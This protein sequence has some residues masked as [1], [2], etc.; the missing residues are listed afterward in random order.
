MRGRWREWLAKR[1]ALPPGWRAPM[2]YLAVPL[3]VALIT[4][5]IAGLQTAFGLPNSSILYLLAVLALASTVGGR[6]AVLAACLAFLADN[7]F[8]VEPRYTFAIHDPEQWIT[9]V[10][11]LIVAVVAGQLTAALR[12]RAVEAQ[13]R[14]AMSVALFNSLNLALEARAAEAQRREHITATLYELS[15]ALVAGQAP[16][17][18]LLAITE[19]IVMLLPVRVCAVLLPDEQGL[20]RVRVTHL[21]RGAELAVIDRNEAAI[22]AWLA[23]QP[24]AAGGTAR[25]GRQMLVPLRAG[26]RLIGLL[27]VEGDTAANN[28]AGLD[29]DERRLLETFAAQA[30]LALEQARLARE[31][32]RAEILTR[33]DALKDTLLTSVSHDLRTPLAAIRAAAGSLLQEDIAWDA[34]ARHEF[35]AA[36]DDEAARLNRLVG[37]LLDMSRIDAGVLVAR[38]ELYPL[39]ALL[40]A[41]VARHQ[42][43]PELAISLEVAADLPPV[44]LD[45]VQIDQVLDNLLDNARKYAPP[46]TPVT[47]SALRASRGEQI[48]I[49][50]AD[51]GPGI[52][53]D[54]RERIF[55]KFGRLDRDAANQG[56]GLGLAIARGLVDA[57]GGRLWVEENPS[58]GARFVFSLPVTGLPV[59]PVDTGARL[60]GTVREAR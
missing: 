58:G 54:E 2:G 8:F 20:L 31:A 43:A 9:L 21:A 18:L 29:D 22:H 27:R 60:A 6:P 53:P 56:S 51:R 28:G 39:D 1:T 34:E 38:K 55:A 19:R 52:P 3:S 32:L 13:R 40:R 46:G 35:A 15:R 11:F 48:L 10:V 42:Y 5:L 23:A 7:F 12:T 37:N 4:G 24:Q 57:H 45:P 14:E 41:A 59:S 26:E 36:I 16:D 44:P 49:S 50:V 17:A 33:A 47:V 30:A 25:Y